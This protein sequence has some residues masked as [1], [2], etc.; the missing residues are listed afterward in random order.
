M[1]PSFH[2]LGRSVLHLTPSFSI[3][4][5]VTAAL[6]ALVL[7]LLFCRSVE[8][9]SY[10]QPTP[11]ACS[12]GLL[13]LCLRSLNTLCRWSTTRFPVLLALCGVGLIGSAAHQNMAALTMR[14][15]TRCRPLARSRGM[16][17][18]C[19]VGGTTGA[20][21]AEGSS[22]QQAAEHQV[23]FVRHGQSTW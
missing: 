4:A 2:D 12:W 6:A 21:V 10:F 20:G 3:L 17:S 7:V 16:A 22:E 8:S 9:V 5:T 11:S 1:Q 14:R 19:R 15:L 18:D 13:V 23:V